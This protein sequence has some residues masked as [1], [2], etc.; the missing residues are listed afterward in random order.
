[1]TQRRTDIGKAIAVNL[2]E[3]VFADC[4]GEGAIRP[5]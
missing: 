4:L 5:Q 3:L 2:V 1:M